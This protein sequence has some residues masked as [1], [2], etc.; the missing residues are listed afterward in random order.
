M[1]TQAAIREVC[2]IAMF[3]AAVLTS[4][5]DL[6]AQEPASASAQVGECL[7]LKKEFD[8]KFGKL[9]SGDADGTVVVT[10]ENEL[11]ARSAT[12]GVTLIGNHGGHS[13]Y[14]GAEIEVWGEAGR[15]YTIVLPQTVTLKH[16]DYSDELQAGQFTTFSRN[17]SYTGSE[18]FTGQLESTNPPD[19]FYVGGVLE[20]PGRARPG[21]YC[22]DF[23]ICVVYQ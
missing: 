3:G 10:V 8:L 16:R 22:G 7:R 12:G 9:S 13:E 6:R 17:Y 21:K 23:P 18:P 5:G 14:H 19:E 15:L 1:V 2:V 11:S 20:V 4:A